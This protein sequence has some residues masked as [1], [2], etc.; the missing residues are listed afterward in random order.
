MTHID[1]GGFSKRVDENYGL[2]QMTEIFETLHPAMASI[3]KT[4]QSE[5]EH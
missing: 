2:S 4:V 3:A 5:K 1:R